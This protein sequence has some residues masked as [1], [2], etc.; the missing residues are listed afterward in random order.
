MEDI[1]IRDYMDNK[2]SEMQEKQLTWKRWLITVFM[3]IVVAL[4]V[5]GFAWSKSIG[6]LETK[7]D[8]LWQEYVPGDL[9]LAIVHSFD[10]Q[11]RYVLGLLN[12]DSK[13]AEAALNEFIR[14]RDQLYEEAKRTRGSLSP[15]QGRIYD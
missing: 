10:L 14:F 4:I 13:E 5:S 1:E 8:I 3:T 11:N 9:F 2:F 7:T 12:G 15:T 6:R